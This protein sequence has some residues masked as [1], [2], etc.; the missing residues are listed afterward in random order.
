MKL[1]SRLF[2]LLLG[3]S[4][5]TVTK[6]RVSESQF[7]DQWQSF[8]FCDAYCSAKAL[9]YKEEANFQ[10]EYSLNQT[11]LVFGM[12][13]SVNPHVS[14]M[15]G[16]TMQINL[17][18][19]KKDI[20]TLMSSVSK[21]Y[22]TEMI[23]F[24]VYKDIPEQFFNDLREGKTLRI[25]LKL[26]EKPVLSPY[27]R[28]NSSHDNDTVLVSFPL[29]GSSEAMDRAE[30]LNKELIYK[31][32]KMKEEAEEFFGGVDTNNT[33]TKLYPLRPRPFVQ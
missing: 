3:F 12:K 4:I 30:L 32:N 20:H 14:L 5:I 22:D 19:D 15:A 33:G 18:V 11:K 26:D 28:Y 13:H 21:N 7:H 25:H 16:D 1:S 17:R 6:A 24:T 10:V 29:S 23:F 27:L 31:Y 8:V 9:C 2:V